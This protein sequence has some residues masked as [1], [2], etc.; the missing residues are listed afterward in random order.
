MAGGR[1]A[2]KRFITMKHSI[3]LV[4]AAVLSLW[5]TVARAAEQRPNFVF[6][7]SEDIS[8]DLGCYGSKFV[9]TPNLDRLASEGVRFTRCFTHGPVCSVSR[10]GLITGMYS[11]SFGAM[12]HRSK[13]KG[14]PPPTFTSVLREAGYFVDWPGKTDFNF[15]VPKNAFSSTQNWVG[16][17][18]SDLKQK[19][20]F[21]AYFNT[22][23]THESKVRAPA[24]E[25][26]RLTA[27]LKP[28]QRVD[29]AKVELPPFYPDAPEVRR[30]VA[31][32]YE[33]IT[34]MDY[35]VGHILDA[36]KEAG[37]EKNTV[38][39]F[40]GDHGRGMPRYKRWVYDTGTQ[41]PL[42]MRWP[43]KIKAGSVRDD[44]VT[45][46]GFAPTFLTLAGV[47]VPANMQGKPFLMADGS[48]TPERAKYVFAERDR[49]DE[50]TDRI[51]SARDERYQLVRN[52]HPELPY[53]QRIVYNEQMPTMRVWRQLHN[54]GKLSGPAEAF[55]APT[56][57]VEEFYDTQTDPYEI[58]NL[59]DSKEPA[60][61]AKMQEL[62]T[63]LDG[64]IKDVGDLGA[65]PEAELVRRG[66]VRD[67]SSKNDAR[68]G[69]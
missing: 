46:V 62:R 52:Y 4:L 2:F 20:P 6:I 66:V 3:V 64:W 38:I 30:D 40:W 25:Y 44:L 41:C 42:I 59:I 33:L 55:F 53:A 23:T 22:N 12:H 29:P 68:K 16:K 50:T 65:V 31:N 47:K 9:Q 45:V 56:K 26:A 15:D 7:G 18:L 36:L 28:S 39:V 1:I 51:R 60:H 61:V 67:V 8:P 17:D 54:A 58:H 57:P 10:S 69:E 34:A 49:M 19:Q 14:E 24:A 35:E 27:S 37:L 5:A 48:A 11:M 43:G 32:Y 13:L 21:F 63:A